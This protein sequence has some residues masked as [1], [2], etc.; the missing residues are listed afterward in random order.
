MP[1]R[2]SIR[3]LNKSGDSKKAVTGKYSGKPKADLTLLIA[4]EALPKLLAT[5]A[6]FISTSA[7][8]HEWGFYSALGLEL[9]QSPI[10]ISDQFKNVLALIPS[11]LR[12]SSLMMLVSMMVAGFGDANRKK[13]K[14]FWSSL[15]D[16]YRFFAYFIG[17]GA[18]TTLI[19]DALQPQQ[20]FNHSQTFSLLVLASTMLAVRLELNGPDGGRK[21]FATA[22]VSLVYLPFWLFGVGQ[23]SATNPIKNTSKVN[24]VLKDNQVEGTRSIHGFLLRSYEKQLLLRTDNGEIIFQPTEQVERIEIASKPRRTGLICLWFTSSCP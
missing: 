9:S 4:L 6:I 24:I 23:I 10:G 8:I 11:I 20:E 1:Y 5:L 12:D 22:L 19:L 18:F 2:N 13:F 21:Y 16:P 15:N 14:G 17:I 7:L 3:K